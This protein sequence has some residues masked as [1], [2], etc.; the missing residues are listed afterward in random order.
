MADAAGFALRRRFGLA[1]V[2]M[3]TIQL[4][5]ERG[6]FLAAARGHLEPG[7]L[8]AIAITAALE[9]FGELDDEL[10]PHPDVGSVAGWRF[11]SQPTAVRA[12]PARDA[13]RARA[14]LRSLPTAASAR[15]TT[16]SSSRT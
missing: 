6:G 11:A 8:L 7:G 14:P 5:P 15:R 16:R 3:Q 12:L 10:L 4:L 13:D 9:H 1:I 2:P